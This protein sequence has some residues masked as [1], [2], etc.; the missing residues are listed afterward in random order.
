MIGTRLPGSDLPLADHDVIA[1][2]LAAS[3]DDNPLHR[4]R[5][6]ARSAG[7]EDILVP[8]MLLMAQM[9]ECLAAW[10]HCRSIKRL[11]CRFV[12]PV[13]AGTPLRCD[14]RIVATDPTGLTLVRLTAGQDR[15]I[16]V[17]GEAAITLA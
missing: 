15:R 10:P 17:L 1:A 5:H 9:A 7:F 4:D 2:Y 8:G 14:G 11:Q 6:V 3:G 16:L 13:R 12:E